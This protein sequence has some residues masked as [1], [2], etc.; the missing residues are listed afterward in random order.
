MVYF[1]TAAQHPPPNAEGLYRGSN[2]VAV[3]RAGGIISSAVPLKGGGDDVV[4][5]G[6]YPFMGADSESPKFVNFGERPFYFEI[7]G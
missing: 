7:E 6:L 2:A 5:S 4:E 3:P 1:Q